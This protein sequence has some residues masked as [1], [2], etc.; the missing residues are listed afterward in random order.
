LRIEGAKFC[1]DVWDL[2]RKYCKHVALEQPK[3]IMQ[4]YIGKRTQV[5][6]PYMF[7]HLESKE[8][9]LWLWGLDTLTETANV[10][11]EMMKLPKVK[12]TRIHYMSPGLERQRKRSETYPGIAS[13]F[14][15][16]WS[17]YVNRI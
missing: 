12:R 5:I 15:K 8:T 16:Q 4:R 17:E 13:A 11:E 6:Q 2:A 10:Y 7:G 1:K 14:A 9:W 3:T